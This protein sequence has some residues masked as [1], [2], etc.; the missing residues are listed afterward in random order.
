MKVKVYLTE[1]LKDSRIENVETAETEVF[2][3]DTMEFLEEKKTDIEAYILNV[4]SDVEYQTVGG[5]GGAFTE[6]AAI[7]YAML[8][9][10][11]KVRFNECFFDK[12]KGIGFNFGRVCIG[13]SD[14]SADYYTYVK[15]GDETLETFDISHDREKILPMIKDAKKYTDL[16]MLASPWS[17]PSYMKTNGSRIGGFLK[18]EYYP[19]WAKHFRRF[20]EEYKK[21]GVNI[22]G[23]TMQNEP[24]HR[25]TWESCNY[26]AEQ[27]ADFLGFLGK[28]LEKTGVKILCYD[29]CRERVY[30]RAKAILSSK[31]AAYCDGIANHWY[32]GDHAGELE[33]VR[34][35]FPDFLQVASEGCIG[36]SEE[37]VK[38]KNGLAHAEFYLHDM[39]TCFNAGINYYCVW[40]LLLDEH[41]G[42]YHNRENRGMYCDAPAY[43]YKDKQ[44]FVFDHTYYYMGHISKFVERGAK[45]ISHSLYTANL[46]ACAFKNPDGKIVT[47]CMNAKDYNQ[48]L[49]LRIDGNVYKTKIPAHSAMTFVAE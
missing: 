47:V 9:E 33:A 40:N 7:N 18:K 24:R 37:G 22:W 21:E 8:S 17:P 5:V 38:L 28:E 44:S 3:K 42:P 20:I 34:K 31:N 23:V 25:Q 11:E 48:L 35:C 49:V 1:S 14:F 4:H 46:D 13:S 19:L 43:Y 27:E 10:K 2:L 15:E 6:S 45:V 16:T 32:S 26:T 29:H 12:E 39:L 41:N 36:D 30:E